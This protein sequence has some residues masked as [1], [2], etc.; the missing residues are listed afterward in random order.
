[1]GD[2]SGDQGALSHAEPPKGESVCWKGEEETGASHSFNILVTT[3]G[4]K[5]A[6]TDPN[7]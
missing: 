7:G 2:Q 4:S 6:A 3:E 5:F 1:M